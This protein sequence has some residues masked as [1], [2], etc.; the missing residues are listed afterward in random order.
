MKHTT[1]LVIMNPSIRL[2]EA[3]LIS[4]IMVL[5][6]V[7]M[8]SVAWGQQNLYWT[9][10]ESAISCTDNVMTTS[11]TNA[12]ITGSYSLTDGCSSIATG[13][14]T[15]GT[16]FVPITTDG[17]AIRN[18]VAANG[19][20][21]WFFTLSESDV[22]RLTNIQVYFQSKRSVQGNTYF[23]V[24]NTS[25]Q[26][27]I[28]GGNTYIG[29]QAL[30]YG[31]ADVWVVNTH[32]FTAISGIASSLIFRIRWV[33]ANAGCNVD[34]DNFQ[35]QGFFPTSPYTISTPGTNT[36]KV[37]S[38]VNQLTVEC[39]GG[40]GRGGAR[41][42]GNNVALAGGGGGAYSKSDLSV[43]PGDT[44]NLNVGAG[45]ASANSPGGDSWFG[46]TTT[47]LAKGGQSV[48]NNSNTS[49]AGGLW[50]DCIGDTRLNGGNGATGTGGSFGGG[51]GSSAGSAL[52][53]DFTDTDTNQRNGA[54]APSGGGSGGT[55]AA[56]NT[57]G[58]D[59]IAPGGGGGG[60]YRAGRGTTENPGDGANGQVIISWS[61]CP[62][63]SASETHTDITCFN[64]SNGT[65]TITATGGTGPWSYSV[66]NGEN[67]TASGTNPY[68]FSG[69]SA[70]VAYKIRVQDSI[71][72]ESPAIP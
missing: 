1:T 8:Q 13:A 36:F 14:V 42:T 27:S 53:G 22:S 39:W 29:S 26:F 66:D 57:A 52:A 18:A 33:Q 60:G 9:F 6:S 10:N 32:D 50:S 28:D 11:P 16:P 64:T 47:L 15:S 61:S 65:I 54:T 2:F 34:I 45:S 70:N 44:Y 24:D 7:L 59:G 19:T 31:N 63:I 4:V 20:E 56:D 49:G 46:S 25:I 67:Y 72:C 62:A 21:Y 40:G 51:G 5:L 48:A 71:G 68:T 37:P 23:D 55:G 30:S 38:G 58:V 43:T 35:V 17:N 3:K 12:N 41:T 69:L